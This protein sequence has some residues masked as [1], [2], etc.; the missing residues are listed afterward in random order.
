MSNR[1]YACEDDRMPRPA[2]GETPKRNI[3]IEDEIWLPAL[4]R[5]RGESRTLTRVV[6]EYL[7]TYGAQA[8]PEHVSADPWDV[9]NLVVREITSGR[10]GPDTDLDAAVEAAAGM[11]RALG[12]NPGVP[13]AGG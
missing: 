8:H 10:V 13:D 1:P 9:V 11:L 3:R 5:A 2:T 7:S 12:V 6:K 4:E